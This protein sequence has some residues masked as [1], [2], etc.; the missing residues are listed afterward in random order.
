MIPIPPRRGMRRA[1][2]TAAALLLLAPLAAGAGGDPV[3]SVRVDGRILRK[4]AGK[5]VFSISGFEIDGQT[6]VRMENRKTGELLTVPVSSVYSDLCYSESLP[7]DRLEAI[8]EDEWTVYVEWR[9]PDTIEALNR[10]LSE[11]HDEQNR[12]RREL[13]SALV[14]GGDPAAKV[15]SRL[16]LNKIEKFHRIGAA[17]AGEILRRNRGNEDVSP[18]L[19]PVRVDVGFNPFGSRTS[20]SPRSPLEQATEVVY[21]EIYRILTQQFG[22]REDVVDLVYDSPATVREI[23]PPPGAAG[24]GLDR[25]VP[26]VTLTSVAID[27]AEYLSRQGTEG[28]VHR[29]VRLK[30][31]KDRYITDRPLLDAFVNE[32]SV[33]GAG[34]RQ[35]AVTFVPPFVRP[36]EVLYLD[37]GEGGEEI[38]IAAAAVREAEGYTLSAPLPVE[39]ISRVRPG[40]AVRRK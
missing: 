4:A 30:M 2:M 34:E 39:M 9:I 21:W 18:F 14:E 17:I 28:Y 7:P 26:G 25:F 27:T 24:P 36:G 6:A 3:F 23:A 38:P 35:V 22:V 29:L 37:P 5:L 33:V 15:S 31:Y 19:F 13:G 10:R 20:A 32:G 8:R 40:M 1:F 11:V 12:L 16:T